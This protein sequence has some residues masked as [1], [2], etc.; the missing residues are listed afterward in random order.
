[1]S[2]RKL[3]YGIV[4]VVILA[5]FAWAAGDVWKSKP[6]AQ[7]DEKDIR[8]ILNESP[9]SKVV[10]VPAA[11]TTGGDSGTE[12]PSAAQEHAPGGGVMGGGMSAGAPPAAPQ[13]AQ[14]TFVVRWVSSRTIR[15]ALLRSQV[16]AGQMKEEDAEKRAAQPVDVYQVLI[17]GP[18]MKPFQGADEKALLAKT[19]LVTKKTKQRIAATG[20]EFE[21][22]PDG[23]TVLAAAFSFPKKTEVGEQTIAGDEK[24]AEFFCTI[25]GANIRASF[26]ISKMDDAQGR[27]L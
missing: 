1:M 8:K 15:E 14:A 13:V 22:G 2:V 21:R 24:G 6:F 19:Y 26:E 7:W 20:V 3:N 18:D 23:K 9:W 10:Q 12:L 25:G 27:D 5:S 17:A 11:W 4:A 16:L